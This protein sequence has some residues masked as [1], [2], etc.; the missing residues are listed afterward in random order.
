LQ[1]VRTRATGP[2]NK[3]AKDL[4]VMK[5]PAEDKAYGAAN[6]TA[7]KQLWVQI[8]LSDAE[9]EATTWS[10][11]DTERVTNQLQSEI[12]GITSNEQKQF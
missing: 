1:E 5:T 12:D 2:R 3:L 11:A 9:T 4:A 8:C 7:N 10:L 6:M